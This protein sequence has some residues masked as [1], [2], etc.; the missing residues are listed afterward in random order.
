MGIVPFQQGGSAT[1]AVTGSSG[2]V[3]LPK[4]LTNRVVHLAN[5]SASVV[6]YVRFGDSTVT[7]ATTDTAVLPYE[8]MIFSVPDTQTHVAAI[9]S[10]AGPSNLNV[11]SGFGGFD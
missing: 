10:A 4:P 8:S 9:G 2:R 3:V 5:E 11:T 7:A 1:L 6:I